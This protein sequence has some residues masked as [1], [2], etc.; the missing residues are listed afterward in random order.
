MKHQFIID[1]AN[2]RY[3]VFTD[4]EEDLIG[5]I[6]KFEPMKARIVKPGYDQADFHYYNRATKEPIP[7]GTELM[8]NCWWQN[9]YGSYF[10]IEYNGNSYDVKAN[11]VEIIRNK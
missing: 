4:T 1:C 5:H 6:Y 10:R 8:V 9:F 7:E 2:G 3:A 11:S